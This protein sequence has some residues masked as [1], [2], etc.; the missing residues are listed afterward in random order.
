[1]LPFF[2]NLYTD[3]FMYSASVRFH[4]YC[5]EC[6]SHFAI[7]AEQL[8]SNYSVEAILANQIIYPYYQL[9]LTKPR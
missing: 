5:R 8:E 6:G 3:E 2:T 7:H 4:F 1:M 9:C